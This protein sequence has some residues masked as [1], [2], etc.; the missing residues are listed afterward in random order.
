MIRVI[1]DCD[2]IISRLDF[3]ASFRA[4]ETRN[5]R[6]D[7]FRPRFRKARFIETDNG[8]PHKIGNDFKFS[9]AHLYGNIFDPR[10]GD[11][12]FAN[13]TLSPGKTRTF[14]GNRYIGFRFRFINTMRLVQKRPELVIVFTDFPRAIFGILEFII[15]K[16]LYL[17]KSRFRFKVADR[18][19]F[20]RGFSHGQSRD[21]KE[22]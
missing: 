11:R 12:Y 4:I 7:V 5:E 2:F 19:C 8:G 10:G 17:R 9:T 22:D 13:S 16:F 1:S 21:G 3:K 14:C 6:I 15:N 18:N 20:S